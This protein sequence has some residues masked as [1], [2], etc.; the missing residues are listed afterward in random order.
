MSRG[1]ARAL[2]VQFLANSNGKSYILYIAK[3]LT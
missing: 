2:H 1:N 3:V